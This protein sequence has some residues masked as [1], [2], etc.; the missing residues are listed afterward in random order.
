MAKFTPLPHSV[1]SDLVQAS[2]DSQRAG[3]KNSG[4]AIAVHKFGGSSLASKERLENVCEIIKQYTTKED[5]I[6][7]SAN[8]GVT[9]LLVKRVNGD[10]EALNAISVYYQ[11]LAFSCLQDS[12]KVLELFYR[13]IERLKDSSIDTDEVL[14]FGEIWS[15]RL[16][17]A[18]LNEYHLSSLLID[19]REL[20]AT[21]S[22]DSHHN[23]DVAYFDK[24]LE[25]HA[26]GNFGKR[27]IVTG[28]IASN[29]SGETITL[30]RNGSD[31]TATLLANF[32]DAEKVTLW[33]DVAGVYSADPR[34]IAKAKPIESL[35]Y[36]EANALANVGTNVLHS[37]TISPLRDKG[38]PLF[39]RSSLIPEA[40]GTRIS[41][42]NSS[43]ED[44]VFESFKSIA[45]KRNQIKLIVK[46]KDW[47]AATNLKR[48][49]F[50]AHISNIQVDY[51][52][53]F[54]NL[55]LLINESDLLAFIQVAK[56]TN[57]SLNIN[58]AKHSLLC[59]VGLNISRL[60]NLVDEILVQ[61]S[62]KQLNT[63]DSDA[64]YFLSR[65]EIANE[66][67]NRIYQ[68][69]QGYI[70]NIIQNNNQCKKSNFQADRNAPLSISANTSESL[71]HGF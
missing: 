67:L 6:V 44:I 33:T 25:R 57:L 45:V 47:D 30:G 3:A 69:C 36:R 31:Y 61:S 58:K 8:G 9:D 71:S 2:N 29:L 59:L 64:L 48:A 62:L 38:I 42:D 55:T 40:K 27:L 24:G 7:V 66:D 22:L 19:A 21:D 50:D 51:D 54:C 34:L 39:I 32:T 41:D 16:L 1:H 18:L 46:A 20:L 70:Q 43:G 68:V 26:Y 28:Y 17:V 13:D 12:A 53:A 23:F 10:F 49:L 35:C 5:I 56:R 4:T 37:K 11:G 52:Q 60:E 63:E 65:N 15:A 14:S